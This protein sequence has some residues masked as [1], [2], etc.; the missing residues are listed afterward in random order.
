[1]LKK[2]NRDEIQA[3]LNEFGRAPVELHI[4]LEQA[5][6]PPQAK[7]PAVQVKTP[8]SINNEINNEP[9]IKSVLDIFDGSVL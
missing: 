2:K 4:T 8:M 3:K 5:G 1:M 7:G 6:D 9:I